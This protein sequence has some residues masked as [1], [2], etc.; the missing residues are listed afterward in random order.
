M[1]GWMMVLAFVWGGCASDDSNK[2]DDLDV[3]FGDGSGGGDA[4]GDGSSG[5]GGSDGTTDGDDG[6]G[7]PA[8]SASEGHD[9]TI[10]RMVSSTDSGILQVSVSYG[11]GCESHAFEL[12]WPSR[13]FSEEVPVSAQLELLHTG[14]LDSC[15][16]W[17]TEDLELDVTPMAEAYRA[18]YGTDSGEIMF[19]IHGHSVSYTF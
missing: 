4:S 1:R 16:A 8:C 19:S 9:T 5:D 2:D 18:A 13:E 15:E 3:D 7:L 11:G 12:C 6:P 17:V 14:P 10:E